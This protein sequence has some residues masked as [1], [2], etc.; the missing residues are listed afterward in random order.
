MHRVLVTPAVALLAG[1]SATA[2]RT[3]VQHYFPLKIKNRLWPRANSPP[4]PKKTIINIP[5]T[6]A[7]LPLIICPNG[8]GISFF[9]IS[10]I[11][12]MH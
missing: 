7:I 6:V 11:P 10:A 9:R 2:A 5:E 12:A 8:P 4:R 3:G 1:G